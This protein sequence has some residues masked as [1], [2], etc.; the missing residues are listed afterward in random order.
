MCS[1]RL[2]TISAPFFSVSQMAARK[3]KIII[4]EKKH[5]IL[6]RSRVHCYSQNSHNLQTLTTA[7]KVC[8]EEENNN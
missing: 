1:Q 5:G 7:K 2:I 3:L 4:L 8:K 6:R